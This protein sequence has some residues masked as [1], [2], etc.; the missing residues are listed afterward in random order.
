MI[1]KA[2]TMKVFADCHEEYQRRHDEIWPQMVE[3]L[4][5]YGAQSYSIFLDAQS[6]TL[7]AYLEIEDEERW[8]KTAE[9]EICQKW[10][11]FMKDV[12]ETNEDHS[13]VTVELKEVFH[14]GQR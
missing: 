1:R 9:R 5:E 11:T 8:S 10:W 3:M 4:R 6:N 13:P 7:F 14:L 12:M 2:F